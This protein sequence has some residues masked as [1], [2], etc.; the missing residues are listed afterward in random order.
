MRTCWDVLKH[1]QQTAAPRSLDTWPVLA[2]TGIV[3]TELAYKTIADEN[4]VGIIMCTRMCVKS[5]YK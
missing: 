1:K 5:T 2:G 3:T 4:H